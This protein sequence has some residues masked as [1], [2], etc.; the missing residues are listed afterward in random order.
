MCAELGIRYDADLQKTFSSTLRRLSCGD[1]YNC[2]FV[3]EIEGACYAQNPRQKG[4]PAFDCSLSD[5]EL[6]ERKDD[7]VEFCSERPSVQCATASD[8]PGGLACDERGTCVSCSTECPNPDGACDYCAQGELCVE[9]SCV[10]DANVDCFTFLDC[11]SGSDCVLSGMEMSAG[12][13]NAQTRSF[14]RMVPAFY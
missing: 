7:F 12:R 5:E 1:D 8:C 6:L 14:C 13:G 11:E 9:G 3:T 10:P 2:E 4:I